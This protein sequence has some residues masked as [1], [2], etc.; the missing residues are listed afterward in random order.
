[1]TS[2]AAGIRLDPSP[3]MPGGA[4]AAAAEG[5][6]ALSLAA[7]FSGAHRGR[8][9]S[10]DPGQLR[11][12]LDELE[13]LQQVLTRAHAFASL[14][15][16]ADT[17]PPEHGAL[18]NELEEAAAG[19]QNETTFF[20]LEW[21]ALEDGRAEQLL[22]APALDR[23][24]H[25]LW[26]MRLSKPHRLTEPEERI[27][28]EK[29]LTGSEAWGRLLEEQLSELEV[30]FD[31]QSLDLEQAVAELSSDDR[32]HRARAAESITAGLAPGLGI[33]ARVLN[34]LAADHALDDRLRH[35]PHWLAECNLDNEASDESVRALVEAVVAR[36]DIPQRW[37]RIKARALGLE[38]LRDYD[39]M[40]PVGGAPPRVT[41]E[42]AR[43][44]VVSVYSSFSPELGA[45]ASRFFEDRRVDAEIRPGKLPGG[46]CVATVPDVGPYVLVNFT[47]RIDD[48]LTLAHEL[49][50]GLHFTMAGPRGVLG[51][52]TPVTVAETASVFGETLA[53]AH[54]LTLADNDA[55]RFQLLAHQLDE[56]VATV[57][58]QVAIHRFEAA[59]H[60]DRRERGEL[61]VSRIAEHWM[62]ANRELYGDSLEVT[63]GFR[64]W[65]S[66]VSHVFTTPGYVYAYAYGQ[67]LA[68]SIYAHYVE[69]GEDFVPRYLELLR[70]GGS[71]SPERLAAIVGVDLTDPG[72]WDAGLDLIDRQLAEAEVLSATAGVGL[73]VAS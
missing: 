62:T 47:G 1:V 8:V 13:H 51:M 68:L 52:H 19:V 49:G 17:R 48:V 71:R 15:F 10:Y 46:Y 24:E 16:Y 67:L 60:M 25:L 33:R 20:D 53:F 59:V 18:L 27:L 32:S 43:E 5:R 44:L 26:V 54:L 63:D 38:R 70:A 14:R 36:Y 4:A 34:V 69:Q 50:H 7:V 64:S 72:F 23:F 73:K 65:W 31:G 66:Y 45:E 42:R 12:A 39:R 2:D 6:G 30:D 28:N 22:A 9:G 11:A 55:A 41:W 21:L 56:A 29:A 35:Y 37:C 40:A 57:F 3:L 58:R 61:S